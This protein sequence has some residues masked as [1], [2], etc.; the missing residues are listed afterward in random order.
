MMGTIPASTFIF[1]GI[2]VA[3]CIGL[4]IVFLGIISKR[5]PV[6]SGIILMGV[7][8]FILFAMVLERGLHM[9]VF[10]EGSPVS[11]STAYYVIYGC[12]AAAIFESAAKFVGL[13]FMVKEPSSPGFA[14]Q[15]GLGYGVAEAMFVG[16]LP[17]AGNIAV[18]ARINK[19][20]MDNYI[21]ALVEQGVDAASIEAF[22]ESVKVFYENNITCLLSGVERAAAIALQ[23]GLTIVI[24]QAVKEGHKSINYVYVAIAVIMHALFDLLPALY[25]KGVVTNVVLLEIVIAVEAVIVSIIAYFIYQKNVDEFGGHVNPQ[26]KQNI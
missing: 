8:C 18:A 19:M 14:L 3:L 20:G 15:F 23:I 21:N 22:K 12:L 16:A 4:P 11:T 6:K 9:L 10:R 1:M 26:L 25:Q 24:F 7:I 5:M 13:K 2:A 17:L